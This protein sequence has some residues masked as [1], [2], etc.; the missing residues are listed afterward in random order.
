MRVQQLYLFP[1]QQNET[2]QDDVDGV[3][4]AGVVE[5]PSHLHNAEEEE[6]S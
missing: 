1:L 5:D 2:D 3:P 6:K 4:N